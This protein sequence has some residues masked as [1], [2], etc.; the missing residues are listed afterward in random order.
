MGTTK[1]QI[2]TR[3]Q[4]EM[5]RLFKALAHPARLAIVEHIIR[6]EVLS[7]KDL[8][9]Y[10]PLAQSTI[11]QHLKELHIAGIIDI[12]ADGNK[13]IY[14]IKKL[15]ML[16]ITKCIDRYVSQ[17]EK[18]KFSDLYVEFNPFK[19]TYYPDFRIKSSS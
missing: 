13:S 14:T 6:H 1:L 15:A 11:S 9:F 3:E 17:H 8:Q 10:I 16:E 4:I 12:R 7:G 19:S 18:L 5:A 2:Y